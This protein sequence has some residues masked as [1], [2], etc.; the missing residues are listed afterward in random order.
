MNPDQIPAPSIAYLPI[1]PMLVVFG[2]ATV[3][4]LLEAFLPAAQRRAAQIVVAVL[5]LAISFGFVVYLANDG[6]HRLIAE[7]ALASPAAR[8]FT[9]AHW[10]ETLVTTILADIQQA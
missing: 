10:C 7:S 2:A 8:R 9:N 5:G 3:G 4:V 6:T 1:L